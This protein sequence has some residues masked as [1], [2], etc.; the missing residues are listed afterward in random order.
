MAALSDLNSRLAK[1][2]LRH[3][4]FALLRLIRG[5]P[6]INQAEAGRALEIQRP[7]M[8]TLVAKLEK[9]GVIERKPIDRR[10]QALQLT[11]S[12]RAL[13]KKASAAVDACERD[14]IEKVP[15]ELRPMVM[16]VLLALWQG[17]GDASANHLQKI[18]NF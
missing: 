3:A 7:N 10:S 18:Q 14:L 11:A 12:G 17:A 1:H 16:P 2:E 4:D 13:V 5:N 6:G 8:A 15:A 9:R